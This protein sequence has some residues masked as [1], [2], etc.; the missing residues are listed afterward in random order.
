MIED[1]GGRALALGCD[2]TSSEDVKDALDR[3]IDELGRPSISFN[4]AGIE[5]S[6]TATADITV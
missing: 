5:Q 3:V 1:L 6:I 2:V 4:N